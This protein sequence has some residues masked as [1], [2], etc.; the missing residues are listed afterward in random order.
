[1]AESVNNNEQGAIPATVKSRSKE[2]TVEPTIVVNDPVAAMENTNDEANNFGIQPKRRRTVQKRS[3]T[4][5]PA[6]RRETKP[7]DEV[8]R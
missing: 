3:V 1:L 6:E 4:Q 5:T 7:A 8:Q 2:E